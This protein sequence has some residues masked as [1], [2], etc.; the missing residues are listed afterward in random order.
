MIALAGV[1]ASLPVHNCLAAEANIESEQDEASILPPDTSI[2][3]QVC[4]HQVCPTGAWHHAYL[5]LP[6]HLSA[7]LT[8]FARK[9]LIDGLGLAHEEQGLVQVLALKSCSSLQVFLDIGVC[10]QGVQANRTLGDKAFCGNPESLG[11]VVIGDAL[12]IT[13]P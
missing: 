4:R 9:D 1:L 12:Q 5:F 6:V 8:R 13:C 11:R 10:Q 3:D 2:T 7:V